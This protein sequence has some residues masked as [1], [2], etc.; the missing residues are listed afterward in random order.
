MPALG[1]RFLQLALGGAQHAALRCS[2]H[3][4]R[5]SLVNMVMAPYPEASSFDISGLKSR[6]NNIG[7]YLKSARCVQLKYTGPFSLYTE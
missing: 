2:L 4:V 5:V 7:L 6:K 1:E 3:R